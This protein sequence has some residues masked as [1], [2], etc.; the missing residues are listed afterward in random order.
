[1][2]DVRKQLLNKV[3]EL[4]NEIDEI[5]IGDPKK[6]WRLSVTMPDYMFDIYI[7]RTFFLKKIR[8][9]ECRGALYSGG[10]QNGIQKDLLQICQSARCETS[11]SQSRMV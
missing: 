6:G 8:I 10:K 2:N 5:L 3:Q 1:M 7:K 4:E 11:A 9:L